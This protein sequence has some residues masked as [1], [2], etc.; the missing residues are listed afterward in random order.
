MSAYHRSRSFYHLAHNPRLIKSSRLGSESEYW[1][2][3]EAP[4]PEGIVSRERNIIPVAVPIPA[5]SSG[6][7]PFAHQF[8]GARQEWNTI[9]L[10]R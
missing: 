9:G 4:L 8:G 1:I 5:R 3:K 2:C 7:E 10:H 6:H